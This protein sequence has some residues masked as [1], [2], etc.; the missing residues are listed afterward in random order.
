MEDSCIDLFYYFDQSMKR[1]GVLREY[2]E[3]CDQEYRKILK[4]VNVRWL[5]LERAVNHA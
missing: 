3:F 1:R 4:H 2:Y 5:S